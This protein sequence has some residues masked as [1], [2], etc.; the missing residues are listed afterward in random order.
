[1]AHSTFSKTVLL[2]CLLLP[3]WLWAFN[4]PECESGPLRLAISGPEHTTERQVH[5]SVALSNTGSN[6]LDGVVYVASIDDWR[7]TPAG[8]QPVHLE[9][10][11]QQTFDFSVEAGPDTFN[12]LYP[13]HAWAEFNTN[14]TPLTAHA[15]LIT[16]T[17]F[18]DAPRADQQTPWMPVTINA[19]TEL[20]LWRLPVHRSFLKVF[21]ENTP[22]LL[23]PGWKGSDGETRAALS[24]GDRV[25]R[26][27]AQECIAVH[28]PW[29]QGRAGAIVTE[30]P[31]VVP[32]SPASKLSFGVAINDHMASQG[33]PPSDGVTFRVRAAESDAPEGTMGAVLFERHTD[34]KVWEDISVD[35]SA[36]AGREI[37]LQLETH[38]GP[39]NDTTCDRALWGAP[40]IVCGTPPTPPPF[41]PATMANARA[42]GR[43]GDYDV[44]V[45]PG[46]R[47]LLDAVFCIEKRGEEP[48]KR[49]FFNGFQVRVHG[50]ALETPS[51]VS[52]L[53]EAKEETA[54]NGQ[55]RWRHRFE[56]VL[57]T[58]EV[59]S[60]LWT[61]GS[62]ICVAFWLENT[63]EPAP[64]NVTRLEDVSF[65]PW[66]ETARRVYAGTGNVLDK[67]EAFVL[68]F[69]GHQLATSYVGYEFE[70][71][72]ALVQGVDTA[73]MNLEVTPQ[74]QRY[75]LHVE[76]R[77]TWTLVPA[78]NIWEA[79][80]IW[81]ALDERPAAGGVEKLAG[82][83][84]FDLWGG[85]YEE[86]AE[87][88]QRAFRYGLTDSLVVWHNW[89]RWGYD[90]RLPDIYPPNPDLG[91]L[92]QFHR[93]AAVCREQNVLFAPHDNYIDFYPDADQYSYHHI[94]FTGNRE[95]V[96][97]WLNE[98]R[99]A[100]SY[101]WRADAIRPFME[102]N[103]GLIKEAAHPTAY[104]IDVFSS[105]RP[106]DYWTDDGQFFD[107]NYTRD[108]WGDLFAWIRDELGDSA[109]Q[110]S[111]S[112]HDQLI[113]WLDGGQ[114]NHLR[115]DPEAKGR[116]SWFTWHVKCADAERVPWLDAAYHDR[117]ALHGAGYDP[118]YRGGRDARFHGIYSDD[119]IATEVLTGHPAMVPAPFGR[120][121][122]RKYWLL[123]DLGRAL[124]GKLIEKV[125]FS[126]GSLHRQQVH[127][128]DGAEVSVNRG[129]D[130][131]RLPDHILP[132][133]GY[134]AHIP[135]ENVES[136]IESRQGVII[137]WSKS[138]QCWYVNGRMPI[139]QIPTAR[140]AVERV[141]F[142]GEN[143]AEVTLR[144]ETEAPL[145]KDLMVFLHAMDD[146]N[147]IRFQGDHQ[148]PASGSQA[149]E[150]LHST[151]RMKAPANT[152]PGKTLELR[153]GLYD[154]KTGRREPLKGWDDGAHAVR[155]GAL[156][157]N[158]ENG[159]ISGVSW[160]T[161]E[162]KGTDEDQRCNPQAAPIDF[163]GVTTAGACRIQAEGDALVITPLPESKPFDVM[164]DWKRLPWPLPA[165]K[166]MTAIQDSG[167]A[168][169]S[170][171]IEWK[172]ETAVI[173][174]QPGVFQ[175]RLQ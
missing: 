130:N 132:E 129:A 35:L 127:W 121:V 171:A 114:A 58:F 140:V 50:D 49:L 139:E 82:R 47:G 141:Q 72:I 69:D 112:G 170:E 107:A 55:L 118:R 94:A 74:T 48:P 83:F 128:Q 19:G 116:D 15:V 56:G 65:G 159:A 67:P 11:A 93:L 91:T 166:T 78:R 40:R 13:F 169:E 31:L 68:G 20:P 92:E 165:P 24:M 45:L 42:L 98:G 124:A 32:A 135:S 61:E 36:Y 44:L 173:H 154:P 1:M 12:A 89:Q 153:A 151:A 144:W 43:N 85:R 54:A 77:Q 79:V 26:G 53:I 76:N 86:S 113:G 6:A 109:P 28:P 120:E 34:S 33:E 60:E 100:Q 21:S 150:V 126:E 37:R 157:W 7:V 41:P 125:D 143:T 136:A 88:L 63:P 160:K 17:S 105:I 10:N 146:E 133:Y 167:S 38:P 84:V 104:F 80:K 18:P 175:Y 119:Y 39:K 9:G 110:I 16:E 155:L 142:V 59:L 73:P 95:P 64:W 106:Y 161:F 152:A 99:G 51:S 134:W 2:I 145:P 27:D 96:R 62:A 131:W 111:E 102:R 168:S 122:V 123:H 148:P 117:F 25:I 75:T 138:P 147:V 14:E 70:N 97:G 66:S 81:R 108:T 8:K 57:G 46:A 158:G 87:A 29:Y 30:F 90:Y 71:G 101:R 115:V 4:K 5:V 149:K 162:P 23:P 174:C 103:I 22:R 163:G 137:E 52:H 164:I 172:E 156:T 3:G